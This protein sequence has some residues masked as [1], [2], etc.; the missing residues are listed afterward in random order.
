MAHTKKTQLFLV[1]TGFACF[2]AMNSF[3]LWGFSFLPQFAFGASAQD[4]WST[5]VSL[6]NI[7]AFFVYFLGS[8][9]FP[10]LF[11]RAPFFEAVLLIAAGMIFLLGFFVT[12]S[13]VML[14]V[15]AV[16][17]G[18]GTTCCFICWETV[19]SLSEPRET[20]K[21]IILGSVLSLLP[22]GLFFAFGQ[23]GLLFTE[24][25]LAFCNLVLLFFTLRFEGGAPAAAPVATLPA[26][27]APRVPLLIRSRF[28][29]PLLCIVMIGVISPVIGSV[30]FS[31][32]LAF[33]E[34]CA[35]VFA[36]NLVSAAI[37][38]VV[39]L[40]LD[41]E[42]TI[43]KAYVVL[44]PV[45]ITA[46]LAF[47]FVA[48]QYRTL[49]LFV[50]SFGFTLFSIVMMVSCISIARERSLG[51]VFV[52]ALFAG[53]TYAS[54]L[55][56]QG[57]A[58]VIGRSSLSQETQIVT[59]VFVLLYGCSLVMF[60]LVRKSAARPKEPAPSGVDVL[61]QAC[62]QLAAERGLSARQT[63]VLDLLAH[64]YDV[65]SI[66]KKLFISEN[67][68]RTHTKKI[69]A[70]LDVHAKQEIVDLVNA[71]CG[72]DAQDE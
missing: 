17:V 46:F 22:F 58:A 70:L 66:A 18:V 33:F 8:T 55:I 43:S 61:Q 69:Y 59:S 47:P 7:V 63:E 16:L 26:G 1:A 49:V 44:F 23:A 30:A 34:S 71:R 27:A 62:A 53:V 39:W 37:L 11:D 3:S 15:S 48:E 64:G 6:S 57:L 56:G 32:D 67:T 25:L 19:L 72:K 14:T 9:R 45:L 10:R 24:S 2:L 41:K 40:A 36:A 51:L 42:T 21:Q 5:P 13:A 65:P 50:G 52:Y 68:V 38:A 54:R 35:I 28:W 4:S 31:D 12:S 60:I 20:K 29:K